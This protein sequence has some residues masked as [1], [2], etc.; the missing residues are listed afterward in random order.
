MSELKLK[1]YLGRSWI[2]D[3]ATI[4]AVIV[5]YPLSLLLIGVLMILVLELFTG[6]TFARSD[7]FG[8]SML[9]SIPALFLAM[10]FAIVTMR[11]IGAAYFHRE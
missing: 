6:R 4:L 7:A 5:F 9:A 11:K 8:I 1:D 3:L 10:W 2:F